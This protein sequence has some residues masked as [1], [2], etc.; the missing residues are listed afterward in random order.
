MSR[1][2][3]QSIEVEYKISQDD[4]RAPAA[5]R[6]PR[7]PGPVQRQDRR[8]QAKERK[9]RVERERGI[10][11]SVWI[12]FT[13]VAGQLPQPGARAGGTHPGTVAAPALRREA[14]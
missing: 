14:L 9:E 8:Q 2:Q 7:R 5:R 11:S 3:K 1:E 13:I 12:E 10:E 4:A 6:L